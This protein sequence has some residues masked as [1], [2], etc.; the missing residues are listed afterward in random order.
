MKCKLF[1]VLFVLAL[2]LFVNAA[3]VRGGAKATASGK[4]KVKS[5]LANQSKAKS[6][7]QSL[8]LGSFYEKHFANFLS[9]SK[10]EGHRSSAAFTNPFF[11]ST[12]NRSTRP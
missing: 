3:P 8:F 5:P 12:S 6:T 7:S 4:G 11:P 2:V 10:T 1:I 9:S